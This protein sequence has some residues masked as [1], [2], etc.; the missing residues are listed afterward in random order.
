MTFARRLELIGGV[1]TALLAFIVPLNL[2]GL[3]SLPPEYYWETVIQITLLFICPGL[4]VAV[5]SFTH[6]VRQRS[7]GRKLL[8]VVGGYYLLIM[9]FLFI[10]GGY[11]G[12]WR[13]AYLVVIPSV[14]AFL[15][16]AAA[17]YV[18]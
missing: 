6:A 12:G 8:W 10:L 3:R 11:G 2:K 13:Q 5:G 15:T 17:I 14:A 1:A 7:W 16:L 4:I 18:R 9:P